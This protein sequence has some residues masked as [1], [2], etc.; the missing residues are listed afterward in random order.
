MMA[1]EISNETATFCWQQMDIVE[2]LN[3][4]LEWWHRR[5]I[6]TVSSLAGSGGRR[7]ADQIV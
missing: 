7:G 2:G 1:A 6:D 5:K 4:A 3:C